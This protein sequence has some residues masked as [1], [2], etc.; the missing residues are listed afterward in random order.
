MEVYN[1]ELV[2][3][4]EGPQVHKCPTC[5]GFKNNGVGRVPCARTEDGWIK[6]PTCD[7]NGQIKSIYLTTK[8]VPQ[9][10]GAGA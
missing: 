7:G 5:D 9:P 8:F 1:V 3:K 6:C 2:S 10:A 4:V